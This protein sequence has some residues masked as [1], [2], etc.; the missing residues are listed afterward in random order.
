MTARLPEDIPTNLELPPAASEDPWFWDS[1]LGLWH[2]C[3]R[4]DARGH[5]LLSVYRLVRVAADE[6]QVKNVTKTRA[7]RT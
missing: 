4:S 3:S 2:P 1:V 6:K 5:A 7:E